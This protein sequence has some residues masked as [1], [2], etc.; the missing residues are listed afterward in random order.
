MNIPKKSLSKRKSSLLV[1]NKM[2]SDY[3]KEMS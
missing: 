2:I 1:V 3:S